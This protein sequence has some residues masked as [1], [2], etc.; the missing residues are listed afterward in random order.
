[1]TN[2]DRSDRSVSYWNEWLPPSPN[3]P[4][5]INALIYVGTCL[6]EGTNVS[7]GRGTEDPFMLFGA[8]WINSQILVEKLNNKKLKG[9]YFLSEDFIP[10]QSKYNG[11][12]C[13]GVRINIIDEEVIN[14]FIIGMHIIDQIYKNHPNQFEF[15]ADFFDKLYG[16]DEL[17]SEILKKNDLNDLIEKNDKDIKE[18]MQLRE[19][20]LLY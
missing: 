19:S 6:L 16:S 3:I 18:F 8:P 2:W 4:N 13:N 12:K 20:I 9:V 11:I 7:E 15:K 17:R 14:P 5:R 10:N 1:M